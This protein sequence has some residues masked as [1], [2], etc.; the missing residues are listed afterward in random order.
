[1]II[2][3]NPF[4]LPLLMIMWSVDAWLFLALIRLILEKIAPTN[5]FSKTITLLTDLLPQLV[6]RWVLQWF[7]KTMTTKAAWLLTIVGIIML[8]RI[9]VW[10]VISL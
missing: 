9:L 3:N 6:K 1:M 7:K 8:R 5:Q 10:F 4:I 2:V